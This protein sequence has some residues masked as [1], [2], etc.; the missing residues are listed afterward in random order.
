MNLSLLKNKNFAALIFGSAVSLIGSNM[1]Q[2]ALSLYV[3]SMTQSATLFA[4]MLAISVLPRLLLSPI[5]GVFGDWFDRKTSI[6]ALNLANGTLVSLFALLFF[7]QGQLTIPQVYLMIIFMEIVEIFYGTAMAAV[8]PSILEKEQL[9][10]ANTLKAIINSLGSMLSP[11]IAATLLGAF[12]L[13]PIM[14]LNAVSFILC[15]LNQMRI[16]IPKTNKKPEAINFK[17]F[18]SDFNDGLSIIKKH[19]AIQVIIGLGMILNFSLSPIFSVGLTL[20][21]KDTLQASDFQFGLFSTLLSLSMLTGPMFLA[22][23]AKKAN[24][25]RLTLTTFF[26]VALLIGSISIVP[27]LWHSGLFSNNWIPFAILVGI[28]FIIGMVV[29]LC[30]IAIGTLFDSLVPKEYMG[31]A[32]SVMNMG[33]MVAIPVGQIA[34]GYAFDHLPEYPIFIAVS[35]IVLSALAYYGKPLL[36][37]TKPV[38]KEATNDKMSV[39]TPIA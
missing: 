1:Q 35:V 8:T 5:A 21:V 2:F 17:N 33:L 9:F 14:I 7:T 4:S 37:A 25:G 22:P 29:G 28:N 16:A 6:V 24:V 19:K 11:L 36:E 3:L 38:A 31:R 27:I 34:A 20:V 15:G 26:V 30:N 23:L 32:A 39:A 18:Y 10:D 13:L 12:G